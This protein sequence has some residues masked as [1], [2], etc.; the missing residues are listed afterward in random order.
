MKPIV[1]KIILCSLNFNNLHL[2]NSRFLF[3][4]VE[5]KKKKSLENIIKGKGSIR[6]KINDLKDKLKLA[7]ETIAKFKTEIDRPKS[8]ENV[9]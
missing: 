7:K 4:L 2:T 6:H 9:I 3:V 5:E 8:E 1:I